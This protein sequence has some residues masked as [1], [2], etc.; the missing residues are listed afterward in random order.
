MA[1]SKYEALY[2]NNEVGKLI[3]FAYYLQE[4]GLESYVD[5]P[6]IMVPHETHHLN[7]GKFIKDGGMYAMVDYDYHQDEFAATTL[8]VMLQLD[9][10]IDSNKRALYL[11][12]TDR[13]YDLILHNLDYIGMYGEGHFEFTE[14]GEG[15]STEENY[16]LFIDC[17]VFLGFQRRDIEKVLEGE[18]TAREAY[19]NVAPE[20]IKNLQRVGYGRKYYIFDDNVAISGD[21]KNVCLDDFPFPFEGQP[22]LD[23]SK[24]EIEGVIF[25][26]NERRVKLI[27][28]NSNPYS[29][30][31]TDIR[32][33]VIDEEI[34][35][36]KVNIYGTQFGEHKVI[37]L[38]RSISTFFDSDIALADTGRIIEIPEKKH[39]YSVM[40]QQKKLF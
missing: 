2:E 31:F 28:I 5:L 32:E 35:A 9:D 23:C 39:K 37:N 34:D 27:N 26:N 20:E 3:K 17:M 1:Y 19:Q 15:L 30:K 25:G 16:Y 29:I 7:C 18:M 8:V 11:K 12:T 4:K 21:F 40:V 14:N 24:V 38:D 22:I 36:S 33:A 10:S 6:E 13:D